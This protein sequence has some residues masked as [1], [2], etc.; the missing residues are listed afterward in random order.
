MQTITRKHLLYKSKVEYA[1]WCVNHVDGCAHGCKYPCYAMLA[2]KRFG[3]IKGYEDW[4]K[5]KL[6]SNALELLDKEL[7]AHAH[8]IK[9]VHLCFT[10]DPFMYGYPEVTELSLKIIEKIN[11][12]KIPVTTLTKGITPYELSEFSETNEYGITLTSLNEVYRKV[13]EPHAAPYVER[14]DALKQLNKAGCG[15]WISM[16]PYASS[17]GFYELPKL[18]EAVKFVD[19]IVFGRWNYIDSTSDNNPASQPYAKGV[20]LVR[21]FCASNGIEC[22]IKKG[23][24]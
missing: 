22:V 4:I 17:C 19:R 1:D 15:T 7:P 16:E 9:N 18:L 11:S 21:A 24:V 10:T 23:T 20:A 3:K 13:W 14:L 5:P 8:E 6:V 12:F 2:A